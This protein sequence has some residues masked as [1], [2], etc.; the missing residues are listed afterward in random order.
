MI[1]DTDHLWGEGGDHRW[2]W[3]SF[4]RGYHPIYMDRVAL[5]TGNAKGDI[6]GAESARKAMGHTRR[7]AERMNLAAMTPAQDLAST[8]YCL[9][10]PGNEYLVYLP[11]GGQVTVDLS[12]ARGD[13]ALE[14]FDPET[15]KTAAAGPRVA[16]G[17][18]REF[19]A[20]CDGDAVLY[21]V[22]ANRNRM[23]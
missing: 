13:L 9:A 16:G 5:L 2:V 15:G 17:A 11:E 12:A 20:P 1:S 10:D 4:L 3:K 14:W 22:R 7:F 8:K 23:N 21:L 19:K 6:A 18:R